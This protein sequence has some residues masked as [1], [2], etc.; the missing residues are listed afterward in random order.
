[1]ASYQ[2]KAL[3]E[4]ILPAPIYLA[5]LEFFRRFAPSSRRKFEIELGNRLGGNGCVID[6][7]FRGMRYLDL[8]YGSAYIPKLLGCYELEVSEFV[9]SCCADPPD[10]VVDIGSAEGYYAVGMALCAPSAKVFTYDTSKVAHIL[11]RRLARLNG[12]EDRMNIRSLCDHAALTEVLRTSTSP[13]VVCDCEGCELDL[14][15]PEQAP[16]LKHARLIVEVHSPE[17]TASLLTRLARTHDVEKVDQQ[18]RKM[19]ESLASKLN[20]EEWS[21]ASDEVRAPGQGWLLCVPR[22]EG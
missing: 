22:G 17:I 7:P 10:V 19:P 6:G 11:T 14:M 8:S 3:G 21:R 13:L 16:T 15:D 20:E 2:L 1:M 18:P 9:R 12:V 4:R 5:T